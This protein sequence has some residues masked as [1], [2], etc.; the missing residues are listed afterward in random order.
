[1]ASFPLGGVVCVVLSLGGCG[2][3]CPF[4]LWAG[5]QPFN[6]LGLFDMM[7]SWVSNVLWSC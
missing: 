3:W 5:D 1:M 4:S 7:E 2:D 6:Y